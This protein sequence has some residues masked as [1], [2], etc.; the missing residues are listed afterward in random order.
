[1][2]RVGAGALEISCYGTSL[3]GSSRSVLARRTGRGKI[4]TRATEPRAVLIV[5]KTS[6]WN[7]HRSCRN[8]TFHSDV[9]FDCV[10]HLPRMVQGLSYLRIECTQTSLYPAPRSRINVILFGSFSCNLFPRNGICLGAN[11]RATLESFPPN[12][13]IVIYISTRRVAASVIHGT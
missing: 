1:M 11:T 12:L 4:K 2:E 8:E 3:P 13:Q 7:F 10:R 9:L 6:R 5:H